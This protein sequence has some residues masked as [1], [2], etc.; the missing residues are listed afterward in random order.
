MNSHKITK[1]FTKIKTSAVELDF[2][3]RKV[4]ETSQEVEKAP[5]NLEKNLTRHQHPTS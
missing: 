2:A 3:A 5:E 1:I 4:A